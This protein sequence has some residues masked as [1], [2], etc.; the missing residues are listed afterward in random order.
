MTEMLLEPNELK[1]GTWT[2]IYISS[3]GMRYNG[4]LTVTTN[5]LL[6]D[7]KFDIS[8]KE[9][10]DESLFIKFGSIEYFTIKKNRI[11]NVEIKKNFIKKQIVITLDNGQVHTFDY[12]IQNIDKLSDAINQ[13]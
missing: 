9:L 11:A 5:R 13:R 12:G 6:Y 2:I 7:A 8:V 4:N 3:D 1:I 10:F